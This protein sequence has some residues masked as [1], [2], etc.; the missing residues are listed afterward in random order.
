M[1]IIQLTPTLPRHRSLIEQFL[2]ENGL[3]LDALD[4]Y[5]AV[6][7][8][9]NG[10]IIAGGG[11]Q[12]ATIKCLAVS[13]AHRDEDIAGKIVSHLLSVANAARHHTVRVFTKPGYR[14]AF[15]SMSFKLL[16]EAPEAVFMETGIGGID[17]YTAYLRNRSNGF[18]TNAGTHPTT[19]TIVMNANPFTLGHQY[20]VREAARQVDRLFVIAVKED[21]SEYSY[22]ERLA[23]IENGCRDIANVCVC[24]GSDYAISS[25]TFPTYFLKAASDASDT[26]MALDLDLFKRHIAPALGSTVRFAGSEPDDTF[27]RRY[28][29]HMLATLGNVTVVER[30]CIEGKAVS[31][32]AVRRSIAEGN[33]SAAATLVPK[34]TLPYLVAHLATRALT[35]ELDTTPKPG[36]VDRHDNGS[37]RDMDYHLMVKSIDTLHPYFVKLALL[38]ADGTLPSATEVRE[39]GIEAERA[40]LQATHGTNTHRGA[41]FSLGLAVVAA[42]CTAAKGNPAIGSPEMQKAIQQTI[43][44][45]ASGFA[46]PQGTHGAEAQKKQRAKGALDM[47]RDGYAD[48]FE[49]WLPFRRSVEGDT[50]ALHKTL[51]RIMQDLDD[52]NILHRTDGATLA[53]VKHEASTVLGDFSIEQAESLNREFIRRGISPGGSADM[54]AL[55]EFM[56]SVCRRPKAYA[57][58]MQQNGEMAAAKRNSDKENITN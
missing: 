13:A 19:G 15:E 41:L 37:H 46:A 55:T 44:A 24:H 35:A 22:A 39:V 2:S 58:F 28:N 26:Q 54:L 49:S 21:V 20:L 29:Q 16:A 6:C 31:A 42:T 45:L 43:V 10:T 17:E 36:L 7:D 34:T 40:M 25:A 18:R 5:A 30:L 1:E 53:W 50:H 56:H 27:T 23:M 32:S 48:L 12:G 57:A 9:G 52:T 11:L 33:L 8:D 3:R 47:A 38:A 14:T 4:Y 51:L